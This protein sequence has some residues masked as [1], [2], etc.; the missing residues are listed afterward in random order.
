MYDQMGESILKIPVRI[1]ITRKHITP[2]AAIAAESDTMLL[3]SVYDFDA[4]IV[5][6]FVKS[7]ELESFLKNT[8]AILPPINVPQINDGT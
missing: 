3:L 2:K 4:S 7:P 6:N 8:K 1:S 5:W